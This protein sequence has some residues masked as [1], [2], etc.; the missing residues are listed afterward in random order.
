M[1]HAVPV[2]THTHSGGG[3]AHDTKVITKNGP[4]RGKIT[5]RYRKRN[6]GAKR[7]ESDIDHEESKEGHTK[8]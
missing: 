5:K 8:Y 6:A 3:T 2:H 1:V 7:I 4:A